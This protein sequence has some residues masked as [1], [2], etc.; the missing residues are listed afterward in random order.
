MHGC[1]TS[2]SITLPASSL[3]VLDQLKPARTSRSEGRS[4]LA[5]EAGFLLP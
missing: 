1:A 2:G 3:L 4:Y 5:A